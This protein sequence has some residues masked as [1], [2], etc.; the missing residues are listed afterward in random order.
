MTKQNISITK[1]ILSL[2]KRSCSLACVRAALSERTEE[3][4]L[5]DFDFVEGGNDTGQLFSIGD[6]YMKARL[7][8]GNRC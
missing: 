2:S 4:R 6:L 8:G 5:P 3:R 7:V 1:L